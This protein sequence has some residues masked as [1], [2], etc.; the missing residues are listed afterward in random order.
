MPDL[1]ELVA[2]WG[3]LAIFL[4]V[5]LG[6]IGLP[7]PEEAILALAGYLVWLGR[8]RLSIVLAVGI[9]SA[10]AGDTLGYWLGHRYG[11]NALQRYARWA[12]GSPEQFDRVQRFVARRGPLGVFAARFI[13]GLR[14]MAGP[15]AGALG[16]RFLAFLVSNVLGAVVYVPLATGAGY[17]IG[18]GLGDYVERWRR[19]V[20][21]IERIALAAAIVGTAVV[22]GWRT[23]RSFRARRGR[24]LER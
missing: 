7:V 24:S 20:G 13:P 15:L 3:Y 18:Y 5:I 21:E 4:F 11:R 19:R 6:N 9:V 12:L 14:F 17:A 2:H 10:I 22:L 16:V 1:G 23:L 8:L